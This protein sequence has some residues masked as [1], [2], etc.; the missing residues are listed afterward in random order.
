MTSPTRRQFL[1]TA[2]GAGL[3]GWRA[4]RAQA[5][6]SVHIPGLEVGEA[7]SLALRNVTVIDAT[8]APA[9]AGM[10]VSIA[11]SRIQ[12]VVP[13]SAAALGPNVQ[14]IEAAGKFLI[15]GLWDM[16]AHFTLFA[17]Q[18]FFPLLIA[19]GVTGIRV[20]GP[21]NVGLEGQLTA[22]ADI[23]AGQRLG[24]RLIVPLMLIGVGAR[25][26]VNMA[27][28]GRE[29]VR[30][31]VQSGVDFVKVHT[32]MSRDLFLA[33]AAQAREH[34]IPVAGHVP[35]PEVTLI[36]ASNAGLVSIEHIDHVRRHVRDVLGAPDAVGMEG[37]TASQA[38]AVSDLFAV[39]RRNGTWFSPTFTDTPRAVT[40]RSDDPRLR[41][42]SAA[43][44]KAWEVSAI[45]S[46]R[47]EFTSRVFR[48]LLS[49]TGAMHKAGVG[50]LAGTDVRREWGMPG[51]WL[52]EELKQMVA[53]GLTPMDALRTATYN[54]A[55]FLGLLDTLGTI[56]AGKRS[57]MVLLDANPLDDISNTTRIN[58]VFTGGR[59]YRRPALE[60]ILGAV[61]ANARA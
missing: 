44:K 42:F 3:F 7:S 29:A 43:E 49:F 22:R 2:A 10:T 18:A 59:V 24:P 6:Q 52:H 4:L 50:I 5:P 60:A 55:K 8:G 41:Y 39:F 19:N 34:K 61:E 58:M 46:E 38:A 1:T 25:G 28:Q 36:D 31:A 57:E 33:I 30:V 47:V 54:P 26:Q 21:Q 15:P 17:P 23:A 12:S 37:L 53:A 56:E 51:F 11:G 40:L 16:H 14:V 20:M 35:Q 45:P 9:R 48:S 13:T 27:E 32:P